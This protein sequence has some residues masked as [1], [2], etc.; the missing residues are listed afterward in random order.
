MITTPIMP[1]VLI[2]QILPAQSI[3]VKG[4]FCTPTLK[5][6]TGL[7]VPPMAAFIDTARSG[8]ILSELLRYPF[9]TH[10]GLHLMSGARTFL[11][12]HRDRMY[13]GCCPEPY[14]PL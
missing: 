1:I 11:P 5:P 12:K 10:G 3:W 14:G 8:N 6:L 13:F 2:P 9:P 7:C 4:C